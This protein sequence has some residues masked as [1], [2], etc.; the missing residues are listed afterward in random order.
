MLLDLRKISRLIDLWLDEDVN[1]YD[2]TAKIMVD[3]DAVA[4]FGMNAGESIILRP[5]YSSAMKSHQSG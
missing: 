1:S 2:L 4:R 3:D 5:Y